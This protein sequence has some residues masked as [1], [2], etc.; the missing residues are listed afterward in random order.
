[1]LLFFVS[2]G[3]GYIARTKLVKLMYMADLEA[4]RFL[5][6]PISDFRWTKR[7]YGPFDPAFY[8]VQD[9]LE[10][11]FLEVENYVGSGGREWHRY[12]T[13]RTPPVGALS[14]AQLRI[15]AD[16]FKAYGSM[17]TNTFV[18][19]VVYKTSPFV[20]VANAPDRTPIPIEAVRGVDGISEEDEVAGRERIRAG[21]G[22]PLATALDAI[23]RRR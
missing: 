13:I 21:Q 6:G 14:D 12:Q 17:N 2:K 8:Q 19:E 1:M 18:K 5:G 10:G 11:S 23:Q 9:S 20:A 15:L 4:T 3:G 16:V 7:D 22:V